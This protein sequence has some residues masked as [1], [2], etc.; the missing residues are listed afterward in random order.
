MHYRK[1]WIPILLIIPGLTGIQAKT[2]DQD[3][4]PPWISHL[5][6]GEALSLPE[7]A[8]FEDF[9]KVLLTN[10]PSL[11]SSYHQW[12]MTEETIISAAALPDPQLKA[13]IFLSPVITAQ[14]P[15]EFRVGVSQHLPWLAELR[16]ASAAQAHLAASAR[17]NLYSL[18]NDLTLELK[19]EM[20]RLFLLSRT[21]AIQ[22]QNLLLLRNWE[23][24]LLARYRSA[25]ASHPDLVK[26]QLELLRQED[27]LLQ[28]GIRIENSQARLRALLDLELGSQVPIPADL[29]LSE[30][31]AD[32]SEDTHYRM[33]PRLKGQQAIVQSSLQNERK[34]RAQT[35][36]DLMLGLDWISIG[37]SDIVNPTLYS[38]Q[39]AFAVNLGI[40]LPVWRKKNRSIHRA[41]QSTLAASEAAQV[42]LENELDAAWENA[43]R[44]RNDAVRQIDLVRERMLPKARES[45]QV[46]ETAYTAGNADLLSLL[47]A[48]ESLLMYE[49]QLEQ[50]R[51]ALWNTEAR[52]DHLKG[53]ELWRP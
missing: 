49:L 10:N 39:D 48:L 38:G 41:A 19:I 3:P 24:V 51:V 8:T 30:I 36:P 1:I 34:A 17:E 33:N 11:R 2:E 16:T 53:A 22:E 4:L 13:G 31:E 52:L 43:W 7:Q 23:N 40:S 20:G 27:Q 35:L 28:T 47:D 14:G 26:T 18:A 42:A 44:D 45:Y 21:R 50:A 12:K 46:L 37:E 15:Q 6:R 32:P 25:S 9:Q 29:Q 5:E